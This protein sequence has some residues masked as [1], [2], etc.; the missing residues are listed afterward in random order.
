MART[1]RRGKD[2]RAEEQL[3]LWKGRL[4][5]G[6]IAVIAGAPAMGKSTLGYHIAAA[7]NVPTIFV[8]TEE[9]DKTV[10]RP[11]V[12]AAGMDLDKAWHHPEVK[13]SRDPQDLEYLAGLID[14]YQAQFINVDP[15]TNH[16]Y[17]ASI[18]QN[19]QVRRVMDP[20][21]ELIE[22]KGVALLLQMH[23]LAR[24]SSKQ[25]PQ[26]AVPAGV[27]SVAKAIYLFGDDPTQ[28]AD[29]NFRV[30][31]NAQKFN[32][33]L[34]PASLRFEYDLKDV[35]VYSKRQKRAV[36]RPFGFWID[37]GETTVTAKMIVATLE[38]K[39]KESKADR[40]A[41]ELVKLLAEGPVSTA[42]LKPHFLGLHP[43]IAWRTVTRVKD[44]MEIDDSVADPNDARH[45]LW[46]LYGQ[47]ADV[48]EEAEDIEEDIV[49]EEIEAPEIPDTI[50]DDWMDDTD[51]GAAA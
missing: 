19:D 4:P 35:E 29:P 46:S 10:W 7:A 33:G 45:N 44:E 12:E 16:L 23:V 6:H 50:P 14:L 3:F 17:G 34:E 28:G 8:T 1:S 32:F 42:D 21:L 22:E 11:R 40:V 13:F 43:P 47:T 37:Q 27:R 20:Y 39:K 18:S 24:V 31:A 30:L 26:A 48:V 49:I 15:I 2:M 41:I 9:S 25:P 51:E 5:V 36:R 38:P